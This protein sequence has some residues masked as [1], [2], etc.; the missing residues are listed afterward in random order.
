[1]NIFFSASPGITAATDSKKILFDARNVSINEGLTTGPMEL[2]FTSAEN[3]PISG[4]GC[5]CAIETVGAYGIQIRC[6]NIEYAGVKNSWISASHL[7]RLN[8]RRSHGLLGGCRFLR[9]SGLCIGS[10][11]LRCWFGHSK[12]TGVWDWNSGF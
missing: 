12:T 4:G 11:H 2:H 5:A 3:K 7:I 6:E 10:F 9:Y 8:F 1:M